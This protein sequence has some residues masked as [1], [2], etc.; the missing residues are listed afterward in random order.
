[1]ELGAFP[2]TLHKGFGQTQEIRLSRRNASPGP[3]PF[4]PIAMSSCDDPLSKKMLERGV[5]FRK[6]LWQEPESDLWR[7][8]EIYAR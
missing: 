6:I 2:G 1:V 7:V 4:A 8:Q 3:N 5:R